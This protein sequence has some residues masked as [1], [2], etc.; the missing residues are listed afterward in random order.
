M[1]TL[2]LSG[3][4]K[5]RDGRFKSLFW[6]TVENAW[7]VDYLGQQGFW[8]CLAIA[9]LTSFLLVI[10]AFAAPTLATRVGILIVTGAFAFIFVVGGMGVR[11]SSWPA[12]ATIFVLY[13]VNQLGTGRP[14]GILPIIIGAVLLSNVRATFLASRWKAPAEGEDRPTRFN[15]TFR[16]KLADQLPPRIWPVLRIPFFVIATLL[17]LLLCYVGAAKLL[18]PHSAQ[19]N[20]ETGGPFAMVTVDPSSR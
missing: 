8:I 13:A 5:E 6:P 7:D 3:E 18:R 17:F 20:A 10:L 15:E 16:D 2:D 19:P 12:A 14:P 11:E 4:R 1:Q 9:I